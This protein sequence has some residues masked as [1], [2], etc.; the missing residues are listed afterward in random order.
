MPDHAQLVGGQQRA[1]RHQ[2][3]DFRL[4]RA[5]VGAG[6]ALDS[7]GRQVK[8]VEMNVQSLLRGFDPVEQ[9]VDDSKFSYCT[10]VVTRLLERVGEQCVGDWRRA[11]G[12]IELD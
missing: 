10:R 6:H 1:L 3:S 8:S 5:E 2:H 11:V 12:D 9:L 7:R 4:G